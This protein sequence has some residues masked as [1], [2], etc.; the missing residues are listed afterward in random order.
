M[1]EL[2][3]I[4][5][6]IGTNRVVLI[7]IDQALQDQLGEL[8]HIYEE[9][10]HDGIEEIVA[11]DGGYTPDSHQHQSMGLTAEMASLADQMGMGAA[12]RDIF[13][14]REVPIESLRA[15][16]W[17]VREGGVQRILLQNFTRAQSLTRKS[18][19]FFDGNTFTRLQEPSLVLSSK[20]DAVIQHGQLE[21]QSFGVTKQIFDLQQIYRAATD[22][23]IRRFADSGTVVI[24]NVDEFIPKANRTARKLL[25]SIERSDVLNA[26]PADE[27]RALAEAVGL[28]LPMQDGKI[29]LQSGR[30]L[31][32]HLKFLDNSIYRSPLDNERWMA[33]S[34]RRLM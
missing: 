13:D 32:T 5:G 4:V 11:F 15:L 22:N 7:Q 23:D 33:N 27:V 16:A 14:P 26:K 18:A 29:L 34:R 3:G 28:Q 24:E 10:F 19:I 21:F 6:P 9:Q 31:V 30:D 12:G 25:F 17:S 8:F 20:V 2:Y 1:G